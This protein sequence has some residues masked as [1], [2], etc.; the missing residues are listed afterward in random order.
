MTV[1]RRIARGASAL[2]AGEVIRMATKGLVILLLT[3]VFLEPDE[4]GLLF[5]AT[6]VLGVA[7]LFATLGFGKSA[8]RYIAEYRETDPGQIPHIVSSALGYNLVSYL[9][10]AAVLVAFHDQLAA[11][12]GEPALSPLLLVGAAYVGGHSLQKTAWLLFQGFNRVDYSALV[13]VVANVGMLGFVVGLL[14]LGFGV[15]GAVIGYAVG[16][17]LAA[18]VGLAILYTKFYRR[19]PRDEPA[20]EGLSRRLLEYSVPLAMTR[21]AHVLDSQVDAVLVG[22]LVNPLA[23][24]YYTLGK[25]ITE[26][27]IAPATA[28]GVAISPAYGEQKAADNLR[29]AARMYE[30]T[31]EYTLS[32]YL[33]AAAGLFI[34]AG[35]AIRLVFGEA[36]LGAVA[37]VQVFSVYVLLRAVAK[38]TNDSLDYLGRARSRAYA[39]GGTSVG[40]FLLNLLLIPTFGAV[41]AA[42][43][44]V[45]TTAVMS[46]VELVIVIRELPISRSRLLRSAATGG[47]VTAGM[48]AVVLPLVGFISGPLSLLAVVGAGVAVW[49]VLATTVG[50]VDVGQLRA[51]LA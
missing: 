6:A 27:V 30:T 4:Y 12:L 47:V 46:A 29:Q 5:F 13:N 44:T 48:V 33:P 34:V 1:A 37:V 45:F 11:L 18:A 15:V 32:L 40:N 2:L 9:A 21:G 16:Y 10:V 20:E 19:Y 42:G 17:L 22:F 49:A 3:R 43:A 14:A 24:A 7:A 23:V 39:K 25:Q 31:F 51:M 41:G 28:L 38:I 35:P 26:F 36:Y 50:G 8:G